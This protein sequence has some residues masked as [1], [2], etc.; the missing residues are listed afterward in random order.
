[1]LALCKYKYPCTWYLLIR[2][3]NFLHSVYICYYSFLIIVILCILSSPGSW[4]FEVALDLAIITCY[5]NAPTFY[6]PWC[7][8][9][10]VAFVWL[11][12]T[13]SE[14]QW[15]VTDCLCIPACKKIWPVS[16]WINS[17]QFCAVCL[18]THVFVNF[19]GSF[20]LFE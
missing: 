18:L 14:N 20:L 15:N 7:S 12:Y 3:T 1:M 16:Q 6:I 4:P 5:T 8:M 13:A 10:I 2:S 19:C 17:F 9:A 11:N